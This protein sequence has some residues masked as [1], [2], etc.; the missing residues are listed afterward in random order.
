MKGSLLA[1]DSI[2][3]G[4]YITLSEKIPINSSRATHIIRVLQKLKIDMR[5]NLNKKLFY[6][7]LL[8][9]LNKELY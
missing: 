4:I 9:V 3:K 6:D 8:I 1:D 2:I 7:N 5:G